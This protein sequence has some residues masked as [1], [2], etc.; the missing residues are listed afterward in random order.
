MVVVREKVWQWEGGW[1]CQGWRH[2]GDGEVVR[3]G[4]VGVWWLG[5]CGCGC[6]SRCGVVVVNWVGSGVVVGMVMASGGGGY[7]GDGDGSDG[8]GGDVGRGV[9]GV[10]VGMVAGVWWLGRG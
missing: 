8:S 2:D 3:A 6:W 4:V 10:G 7:G 5:G 1:G 9:T